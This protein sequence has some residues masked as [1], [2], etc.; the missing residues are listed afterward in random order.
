MNQTSICLIRKTGEITPTNWEYDV[1]SGWNMDQAMFDKIPCRITIDMENEVIYIRPFR[2]GEF[3]N[4]ITHLKVP[5]GR[6]EMLLD[7]VDKLF[8]DENLYYLF[9]FEDDGEDD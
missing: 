8:Q 2:L 3:V 1:I 4:S 5:P 9:T 6:Q 7:T